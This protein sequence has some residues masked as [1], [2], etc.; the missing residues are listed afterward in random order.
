MLTTETRLDT[1]LDFY[2][3]FNP[4]VRCEATRRQYR[5]AVNDYCLGFDHPATIADL[6]DDGIALMMTRLESRGLAAKTINERRGRINCFWSW[7]AKRGVVKL[8]PT[9]P[10]IPEPLRTPRAWTS[11]ELQRLFAA[12]SMV[13]GKV[14]GVPAGLWW[15]SL[16]LVAWD[17]GERITA[18]LACRWEWITDG[19]LLIP[20]ESRKGKRKDAAYRLAEDTL[21]CLQALKTYRPAGELWP[22][23]YSKEYVWTRYRE[24]R[25]RA[26]LPVDRRSSFHRMR[27]SVASHLEAA[28]GDAT[29]AL[30]HESRRITQSYLDPMIVKP[31]QATDYLFRP[32]A[33]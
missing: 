24:I 19:W 16:H 22:W 15:R 14:G 33:G 26:G 20:A 13:R 30:G 10:R 21:A 23:P 1:A 8:W 28:G 31:P 5:F 29:A 9:M 7:L 11:A 17:T 18:L 2:F 12:F 27:R 3:R 25:R 4:R 32:E 6:S